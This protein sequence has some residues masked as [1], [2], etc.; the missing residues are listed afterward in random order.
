[1]FTPS[2]NLRFVALG[3]WVYPLKLADGKADKIIE[4]QGNIGDSCALN[5]LVPERGHSLIFLSNV[6]TPVLFSTYMSKG[7]AYDVLN[8]L[9]F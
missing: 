9:A 1:M 4:R 8:A 3:S 5:Q 2:P 6:E 7:L